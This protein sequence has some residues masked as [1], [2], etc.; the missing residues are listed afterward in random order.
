MTLSRL[1]VA[2]AITLVLALIV[3]QFSPPGDLGRNLAGLI[4]LL[5]C[6]V[7]VVPSVLARYEMGEALRALLIWAGLLGL[8]ALAYTY[9][10]SFGF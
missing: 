3:A 4:G 9:K 2:L 6:A 1:A 7:L 10:S 5:M 8:V